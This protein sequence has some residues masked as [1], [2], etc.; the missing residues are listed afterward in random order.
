MNR[1]LLVGVLL[2]TGAAVA[3]GAVGGYVVA[4]SPE[5]AQ[6]VNV[7]PV[8][9]AVTVK[10]QECRDP[11]VS[12][13]KPAKDKHRIAGTV[14]GG[15]VGGVIGHQFGGGSGKTLA[16]VAGAA[17]GAVAGNQIHKKVQEK[18][19]V[20][21]NERRCRVV[22]R[23]E[24]QIVAYDVRYRFDRRLGTVRMEHAPG[25]RIPVRDG[26]LVLPQGPEKQG[27]G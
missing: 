3:I 24:Q 12:K 15:M 4:S 9:K 14:I 5:Y 17:G 2:V 13:T 6:V 10:Q 27:K 21:A 11:R 25:E 1:P 19:T 16:T 8:T 23:T 26:K 20:K 7:E 22:R 18:N